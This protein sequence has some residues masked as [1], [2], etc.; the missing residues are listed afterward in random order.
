M[1]RILVMLILLICTA[2]SRNPNRT[3]MVYGLPMQG[4]HVSGSGTY[5]RY[6]YVQFSASP[7]TGWYLKSWNDGNTNLVRGLVLRTSVTFTAT[8]V[9]GT[10]PPT[11]SYVTVGWNGSSG[12]TNY[13][14]WTGPSLTNYTKRVT[15]TN[16]TKKQLGLAPGSTNHI[17]VQAIDA[18][19]GLLS[20]YS[21]ELVYVAP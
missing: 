4:G 17:A 10:P 20:D 5:P 1:K 13:Y 14:V 15:A 6:T 9:Q 12:C 7:Y 11:T 2:Q 19:S 3:L 18:V 16:Q 21:G 8:F